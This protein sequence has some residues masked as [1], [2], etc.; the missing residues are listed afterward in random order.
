M[1]KIQLLKTVS[2]E[3]ERW[4]EGVKHLLCEHEILNFLIPRIYRKLGLSA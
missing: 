3:L 4:L 1:C 2:V